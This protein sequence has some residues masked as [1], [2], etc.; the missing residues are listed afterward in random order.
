[1][2][3]Q[4][5]ESTSLNPQPTSIIASRISES[6]QGNKL[7]TKLSPQCNDA[8]MKKTSTSTEE[9]KKQS[10]WEAEWAFSAA[11]N[12]TVANRTI[13]R[14]GRSTQRWLMDPNS[15]KVTRLVTGCVPILSEGRVMLVSASKKKEWILPKGGWEMDEEMEESA[16]R[17]TFEEAGVMG[18]LGP[19]LCEIEYETSKAKKR[20]VMGHA[21][22][23]AKPKAE[24]RSYSAWYDVSKLTEDDHVSAETQVCNEAN[25]QLP[26]SAIQCSPEKSKRH[27][28]EELGMA[29]K[30]PDLPESMAVYA[31]SAATE[32]QAEE[33]N[34]TAESTIVYS[35]VSLCLF[36]LYVTNV[37]STWP[38][39]GRL[40]K[41]ANIE[42]AIELLSARPEMQSIL[43]EVKARGLHCV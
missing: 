9:L 32:K 1:M 7:S 30:D 25:R 16:I 42:E 23:K 15:P 37:M 21:T 41:S 28:G 36:P 33:C 40:R 11:I 34:V 39:S 6:R 20:Q 13:S 27:L 19:K 29:R 24:T 35:H 22:L 17:E 18:I 3:L 14:H 43:M 4:S 10:F 31:Q 2:S 38:E 5:S 26:L 12:C 8:E